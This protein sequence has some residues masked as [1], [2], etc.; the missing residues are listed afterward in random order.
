MDEDDDDWG[1]LVRLT[2]TT[3]MRRG[4][5][6]GLRFSSLDLD[7]ETI[8]IS[9]NCVNGTEKKTKTHQSR[10]LALNTET[11]FLLKEHRE[12][13]KT[14]VETLGQTFSD[15][16]FVFI[17]LTAAHGETLA[18]NGERTKSLRAFDTAAE[19][20]PPDSV[21]PDGPYVALDQAHLARW[22]GNALAKFADPNAVNVLS[23][24]LDRLDPTFTRAETGLHVDLTTALAAF[25]ERE[26]A[27]AQARRA[28]QLATRIG[29]LRQQRR[30]RRLTATIS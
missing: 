5:L 29:S 18:A 8:D 7:G 22:R 14:R 15:E 1:T 11:V 26:E 3:G 19:L 28:E 6:C 10:H 2:M 17:R 13:V 27:R 9:R 20:L 12:R 30:T 23:S 21:D 16:L 25:D 24:A 4:E